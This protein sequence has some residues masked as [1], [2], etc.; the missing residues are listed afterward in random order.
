MADRPPINLKSRRKVAVVAPSDAFKSPPVAVPSRQSQPGVSPVRK[1]RPIVE[2]A[3]IEDGP[4]RRVCVRY[5][6][7][8]SNVIHLIV[9]GYWCTMRIVE[10]DGGFKV[11]WAA[12]RQPP[13]WFEPVTFRH[14]VDAQALVHG[15]FRR[16]IYET[17]Q[18]DVR[19]AVRAD[20]AGKH[21][22]C[23]CREGG[24]CHGD[25]LLE[26]ANGAE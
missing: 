23:V 13:C 26:V 14:R 19:A 16:W 22:G 10:C 2:I 20:L 25:I 8:P 4:P 21:L 3:P 1:R 24:M 18:A 12:R 17:D 7:K 9:T 15:W 11:V 5:R 6:K